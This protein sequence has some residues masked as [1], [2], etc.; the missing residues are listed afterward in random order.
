MQSF[1]WHRSLVSHTA[2]HRVPILTMLTFQMNMNL[3]PIILLKKN[4]ILSK[5]T[6]INVIQ[7]DIGNINREFYQIWI[8]YIATAYLFYRCMKKSFDSLVKQRLS[9]TLTRF[10]RANIFVL[11]YHSIN[12]INVYLFS[13]SWCKLFWLWSFVCISL[14]FY[15]FR[16]SKVFASH[17]QIDVSCTIYVRIQS[18]GVRLSFHFDS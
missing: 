2:Y 11:R 17:S 6:K 14:Y 1:Q 10:S 8:D 15:F 12:R 9:K 13:C 3:C 7:Y 4:Q 5:S 16:R 18:R